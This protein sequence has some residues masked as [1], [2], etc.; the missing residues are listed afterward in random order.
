MSK[1]Q[2]KKIRKRK[3]KRKSR[4]KVL[5]VRDAAVVVVEHGLMFRVISN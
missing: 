5:F 4:E 1:R 2:M 3:R